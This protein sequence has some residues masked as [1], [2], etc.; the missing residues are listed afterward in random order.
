MSVKFAIDFDGTCVYHRFPEMGEDVPDAVRV[1]QRMVAAGHKL[2][3]YT[4]RSN[5]DKYPTSLTDAVEWFNAR[6]I[7][8]YAIQK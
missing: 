2:I 1:M 6:G 5:H 7:E 3:L 4:M 8:L